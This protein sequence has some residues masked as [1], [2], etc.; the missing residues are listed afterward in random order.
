MYEVI[1]IDKDENKV[2]TIYVTKSKERAI[3]YCTIEGNIF[4]GSSR[5]EKNVITGEWVECIGY[6]VIRVQA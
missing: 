5:K 2:A 1:A 3:Y 4:K 6:R